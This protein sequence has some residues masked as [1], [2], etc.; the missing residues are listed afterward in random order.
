MKKKPASRRQFIAS[1][2]AL[3]ASVAVP[4][5]LTASRTRRPALI[6]G[7]DEYQFE[8]LHD[9]ARLP[10]KF[11]WQ[12]THNVAVDSAGLVY[13]IHEGRQDQPDHPA[14]FVFDGDGKFVRAFGNQFQGGGHGIEVRMEGGEEF[15]YV[16]AYQ[17]VKAFAKLTLTGETVWERYAPMQSGVYAENEDTDHR[18]VWGQDRFMPTNFAFLPFDDTHQGDFFLADGYGSFCIH[19]YDKDGNWKSHFGGAGDVAGKFNTPHGLWVDHRSGTP[20]LVVT[21]RANHQLQFLSLDGQPIETVE[22]FGLPA[23]IDIRDDV[24]LVPELLGRVSLL[25]GDANPIVVLGDD[26][27]RIEDDKQFTIRKDESRWND[28]KFIHPH[29]ACFDADGNIYVAEWVGSGRVSK[30]KRIT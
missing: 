27:K 29:D 15:V 26:R 19:R 5:V 6:L 4:Q 20:I 11:A 1:S 21:D 24:M 28:G 16:A 8:F 7:Q 18:K 12:T 30:L 25:D 22:G 2:L 23:N 10:D 9:W 17:Q 3:G 13:V 14:I